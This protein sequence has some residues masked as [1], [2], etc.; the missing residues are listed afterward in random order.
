MSSKIGYIASYPK[1]GNTWVRLILSN[2]FFSK[3]TPIL[4]NELRDYI[5]S[6]TTIYFYHRYSKETGISFEKIINDYKLRNFAL[7]SYL[8]DNPNTFLKTHAAFHNMDK[9][10]YFDLHI[11][12]I[13]IYIVRDPRDIVI[14]SAYHNLGSNIFRKNKLGIDGLISDRELLFIFN[15]MCNKNEWLK[16]LSGIRS[17]LSSWDVHVNSFKQV[18][19]KVHLIRYEDL[20]INTEVSIKNLIKRITGSCDDKRVSKAIEHSSFSKLV[21][22]EKDNGFNER[23]S[24]HSNFFRQGKSGVWKSYPESDVFK[25]IEDKFGNTMIEHG[26]L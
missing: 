22:A 20:L 21:K 4:L 23:V 9:V 2:Y 11:A 18:S 5:A 26:Y 16:P 10:S 25:K 17:H 7:R 24:K 14:S 15:A 6:D 19:D 12:G 13:F 3:S 1:S 8:L